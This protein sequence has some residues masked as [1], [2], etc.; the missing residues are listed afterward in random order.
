MALA[1]DL[2]LHLERALSTVSS[3]T[4]SATSSGASSPTSSCFDTD[5]ITPNTSATPSPAPSRK[6]SWADSPSEIL[7]DTPVF[8]FLE[9]PSELRTK[10]YYLALDNTT[11]HVCS[12]NLHRRRGGPNRTKSIRRLPGL[13]TV[14]KQIRSEA[15]PLLAQHSTLAFGDFFNFTTL[16][17]KVPEQFARAVPSISL[18]GDIIVNPDVLIESFPKLDLVHYTQLGNCVYAP[19]KENGFNQYASI[20]GNAELVESV[21]ARSATLVLLRGVVESINERRQHA[22]SGLEDAPKDVQ[23]VAIANVLSARERVVSI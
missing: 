14:C 7:D 23:L 3:P 9:L 18:K 12:P 6:V 8:P 5:Y 22:A 21:K 15:L 20:A 1:L 2:Q 13:L 16:L 19:S 10:I 17:S 4:S 11:I